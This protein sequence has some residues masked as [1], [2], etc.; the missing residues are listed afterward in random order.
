[1]S[2]SRLFLIVTLV[3]CW[4]PVFAQQPPD[5]ISA[6]LFAPEL[7]M[8]HQQAIGLS[9]AQSSA[10]KQAMRQAQAQFT[11][12]QWK[13]QQAVERMSVLLEQS[14]VDE[15]KALAQ[16]QEVLAAEREVKRT[17]IALLVK[18]K[19]LLSTAQQNQLRA[20][21]AGAVK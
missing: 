19:N 4:V 17:Q 7:V 1:M 13:L 5:R 2:K 9:E 6:A 12:L 14:R 8:Q 11:D 10:L 16:L 18:I 21:R 15:D 20:L 3:F